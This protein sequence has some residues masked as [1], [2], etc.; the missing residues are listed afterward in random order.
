MTRT[1]VQRL[2]AIGSE[3]LGGEVAAQLPVG[4]AALEQLLRQKNGFFA[5]ESALHVLGTPPQ[6][7]GVCDILSWN[8]PS[9]WRTNF[10]AIPKSLLFFAQDVFGGQFGMDANGHVL[11]LEPETGELTPCAEDLEGWAGLILEDWDFMTGH[12]CARAWQEANGVLPIGHRLYPKIPF[13]LG[14]DYAAANLFSCEA[15]QAMRSYANIARQIRDLPDGSKV[16][17]TVVD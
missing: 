12:S 2:L 16:R 10:P 13:V 1:N 15:A 8:E 5:F 14:G 7:A 6:P 4:G 3:G 11:A 9:L 17:L